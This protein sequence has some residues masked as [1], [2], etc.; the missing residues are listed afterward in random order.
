MLCALP[1]KK[2]HKGGVV[3]LLYSPMRFI[4]RVN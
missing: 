2:W 4:Y 1:S 3:K